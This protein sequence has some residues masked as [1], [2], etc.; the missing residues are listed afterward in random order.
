MR[1]F[2]SFE[3]AWEPFDVSPDQSVGAIKQM[4]KDYF[5]VQLSDDKQVQHFLELSY[6]GA[7]L[8]D[9]W[10]LCDVGITP[11]SA[12][13]CLIKQ[14]PVMRVFN[15]ATGETLP[16]MESVFLSSTSVARL[17][18]LVSLQCGLPVSAFRLSTPVGVQLYDC[19]LLHDYDIEVGTT[20]RLDTWDGWV[21]FVQ[22][23]FL[24]HRLTVQSHLSEE[25]PVMRFQLRVALYIAAFLGHLDLAG[26]LLGRGTR[27]EEPVGVH[28]YRQW[29]HQTAH[30]DT[31]KCPIH[32]A[33]ECGQLLILKLFINN[34]Q[35]TLACRS[36]GGRDPLQIAIKHG[37]RDCVRYIATKLCSVVS[38]PNM[39]VPMRIYLQIKSWARLGRKRAA[40]KRCQ[41]TGAPFKARVGDTVLVDGFTQ[42]KMSSK[43]RRGETKASRGFP[44]KA[45]RPLPSASHSPLVSHPARKLASRGPLQLP[46]LRS[47]NTGASREMRKQWQHG[48]RSGGEDLSGEIKDDD[49]S[50]WRSRVPL[51]PIS[52]D[53]N[54]RPLFIY[55]SPNSSHILTASLESFSRRCGRTPRENAIYCLAMASAFTERSWLQQ[56][57]VARTLARKSVQNMA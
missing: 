43:P 21:E 54:P 57:G 46:G 42:P 34:N 52:R 29:C 15:A 2:I 17:K 26:W 28:P 10:A 53:T 6:A 31:R 13:R 39:S 40:S 44:A 8:Q 9:S 27:A 47:V 41:G 16:I 14:K 30:Q 11:G 37:H 25:K 22:G 51:P 1:V 24:G 33:A 23:C 50:L 38:L 35:L 32:V 7:I 4:V 18:T 45:L 55:A 56:L 3:D 20:L 5:H 12:I 36:P 48:G 49:S 19:N